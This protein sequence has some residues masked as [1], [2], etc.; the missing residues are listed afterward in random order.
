M[1][2]SIYKLEF[3]TGVHFGTGM[4]NDSDFVF[5]SDQ[6]FSALYIEALKLELEKEFYE[7][8]Q[9]ERLLFS[10]LFPY[11]GDT[12]LIPKPIL[13]AEDLSREALEAKKH[14]NKIRFLPAEQ[15]DAFLAGKWLPDRN[16]AEQLGCF[17]Q[18][19]MASVRQEGDTLPFHVGTYSFHKGNGLY[20]ILAHKGEKQKDL[21]ETLLNSLSYSGIGGKKGSGLGKFNYF[22]GKH[23]DMITERMEQRTER[24]LLLSTGLPTEEEMETALEGASYRLEKRSGF[25]ASEQYADEFRKKKDLYVFASGS[26]FSHPFHGD[27]YDVSCGGAHPVYRCAKPLF[28]GV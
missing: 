23:T 13:K 16:P 17:Y 10:D 28:M 11:L 3:S 18:Q 2:Y 25:I 4:L 27:I 9:E 7:E 1:E 12:Y 5:S 26:C 20:F 19:T 15:L 24:K 6:L 22:Y 8:V 21:L 14:F